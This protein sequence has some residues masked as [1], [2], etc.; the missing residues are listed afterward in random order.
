[1]VF[2]FNRP[3]FLLLLLLIPLTYYIYRKSANISKLQLLFRVLLIIVLV[4]AAAQP[5]MFFP[6]DNQNILF[7]V[8]NSKSITRDQKQQSLDFVKQSLAE[9]EEQD[10]VGI[11]SFAREAMLER[12]LDNEPNF[13]GFQT[14]PDSNY[15]NIERA[16]NL[17]YNVLS[18]GDM[19]RVVL[20][21]DGN[22]NIGDSS[23][24][25]GNYL[26]NEIPVDIVPVIKEE[27]PEVLIKNV[28]TPDRVKQ[29]EEFM[30]KV[31]IKSTEEASGELDLY[32]NNQH[33]DNKEIK[34][35]EGENIFLFHQ[36]LDKAGLNKYRAEINVEP[37]TII[38][39]NRGDSYVI[40]EGETRI[41]F[42]GEESPG[43]QGLKTGLMESDY[44]IEFLDIKS[45]PVNID[46]LTQYG[47]VV[48]NNINADLLNQRQ[49]QNLHEYVHNHGGGLVVIGGD[50]SF[51]SGN[52]SNSIL[53]R[54]LPL[55]S[56]L[57][58]EM[59]FPELSVLMAID[60]SGSME[61]EQPD[62]H[63]LTKM[64]LAKQAA[65]ATLDV[66]QK[67]EKIGIITFDVSTE[68]VVPLQRIENRDQIVD[69]IADISPGGGTNIYNALVNAYNIL[70]EDDSAVRHVILLSDGISRE[71]N[72]EEI[73]A[74]MQE[75]N[76]SLSSISIGEDVDIDLMEQLALWGDGIHYYT[77]DITNIPQILITEVQRIPR[78]AVQTGSFKT[79]LNTEIPLMQ[80][81]DLN[82][83]P[84]LKGF[85]ATTPRELADD[86]LITENNH[87][88][89]SGWRYGLGRTAAFTSDLGNEWTDE[90]LEWES[91]D[92]FWS[93]IIKFIS[94]Y[95]SEN[96]YPGISLEFD[97]GKII[98][99]AFD[100]HGNFMNFL[101]L[102]ALLSYP[103]GE[104]K[105]FDLE[106]TG[107][108]QYMGDFDIGQ[109]GVYSV[110]IILDEKSEP[111][112]TT[113][114]V[115]SYSPEYRDLFTNY[116]LLES[117][118]MQTGGRILSS[119]EQ[120]FAERRES[121]SDVRQ[122]WLYFLFTGLILFLINIAL[123]TVSKNFL[124]KAE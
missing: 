12:P 94:R 49:K 21:T 26:E 79:V 24:A 29:N 13:S 19:G 60:K 105:H 101:D 90:W 17:G 78:S 86:F 42:I 124:K 99:D 116:D 33:I 51:G 113:S 14:S 55:K 22:E 118:S 110:N 32:H 115:L 122:L 39:N 10:Q 52:Y 25:L 100:Q 58:Q 74:N 16:L 9:K 7:L 69:K 97:R 46:F 96:I 82:N 81:V 120:V 44:Q 112:T 23:L 38:E 98:V 47:G 75:Q 8:D 5:E 66:L 85:V 106:Q 121:Y 68:I 104:I 43:L 107:S 114:A 108:G 123:I 92:Q 87:P 67:Q 11:I 71:G 65:V 62:T 109:P 27:K 95:N 20:I 77:T 63:G 73:V 54:M 88:I 28:F 83:I 1:M 37:D 111:G 31:N 64:D 30:I 61:E 103:S 48:L 84:A 93:G 18:G 45:F 76:I 70:K 80:G 41:L 15:T 119:P 34:L 56:S 117:I 2:S 102:K 4:I 72:F 89:L 91:F 50:D 59:V 36:H 3:V 40:V 57:E 53:E 35:Y 6:V